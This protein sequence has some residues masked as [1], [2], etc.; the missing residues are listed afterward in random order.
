M[1]S[2][3]CSTT[4]RGAPTTSSDGSS[5]SPS[6]RAGRR[7]RR[8]GQPRLRRPDQQ[9]DRELAQRAGFP[10]T[11]LTNA[12]SS[13]TMVP[14]REYQKTEVGPNEWTI[15]ERFVD[16]DFEPFPE[17]CGIRASQYAVIP[18][19][20]GLE[21]GSVVEEECQC[22]GDDHCLFRL[23]WE[24]ADSETS[25]ADYFQ[26]RFEFLEER[27]EEFRHMITD[28]VSNEHY[29]D[30]LQGIVGSS[31][32]ASIASGAVL[33]AGADSGYL[34]HPLLGGS[35]RPGGSLACRRASQGE[36]RSR[37]SERHRCVLCSWP[38]RR[39]RDRQ[40]RR[41]PRRGGKEHLGDLRAAGGDGARWS[42]RVGGGPSPPRTAQALLELS[43]SL[44]EI[45]ST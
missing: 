4:R 28:L 29:E 16:N 20:F 3:S 7:V 21:Q 26:A 42:P 22:R 30:V 1:L 33:R 6:R 9:R 34:P 44:A 17:W 35:H 45:V 37:G 23:R 24:D 10:R 41:H 18:S 38:L 12:S 36:K 32:R 2:T 43:S 13:N 8:I 14:I 25:R 19:I 5:K 15:R 27:F 39:A 11:I 40:A 31:M